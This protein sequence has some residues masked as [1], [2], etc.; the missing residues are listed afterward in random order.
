MNQWDTVFILAR[1]RR[2]EHQPARFLPTRKE[3][4]LKFL[5]AAYREHAPRLIFLQ[6][7]PVFDLLHSDPRCRV[8]VPKVALAPAF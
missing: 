3:G 7:E 8:L 1:D 4:P 6:S 2:R 5:E